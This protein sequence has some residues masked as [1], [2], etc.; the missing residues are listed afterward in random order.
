MPRAGEKGVDSVSLGCSKTSPRSLGTR[1]EQFSSPSTI[2]KMD[3]AREEIE[4]L[5]HLIDRL[6]VYA[7]IRQRYARETTSK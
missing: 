3:S 5:S 4:N 6:R 2:R 1:F 7:T